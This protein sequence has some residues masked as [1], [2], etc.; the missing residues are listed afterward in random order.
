MWKNIP[1]VGLLARLSHLVSQNKRNPGTGNGGADGEGSCVERER[2][3]LGV[4]KH[5][6]QFQRRKDRYL[7]LARTLRAIFFYRTYFL[8]ICDFAEVQTNE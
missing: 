8:F 6:G 7:S 2:V 4:Y 1:E 5:L 3:F